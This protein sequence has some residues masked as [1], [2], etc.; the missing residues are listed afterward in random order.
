MLPIKAS[1]VTPT[2]PKVGIKSLIYTPKQILIDSVGQICYK[3]F[4]EIRRKAMQTPEIQ[5][6]FPAWVRSL[7]LAILLVVVVLPMYDIAPASGED[8]S[9]YFDASHP[10]LL[11]LGN[12][13]YELG[14]NKSNGGIAYITD[15]TSLGQTTLGS[16]NG[17][18]WG[19]V[20][21]TETFW[22][23]GCSY[24]KDDPG[25]HF[26]YLWSAISQ[27]LSLSYTTDPGYVQRLNATVS[28][29]P[30]EE[31]WLDLRL[32]LDNQY[33]KTFIYLQMPCE[34]VFKETDI[35]Q[36]LLPMLPGVIL[37][38]SFFTD[39]RSFTSNYPG[40]PGTFADLLHITTTGGKL[41]LYSLF[42]GGDFRQA[43]LGFVHSWDDPANL[44]TLMIH[45]YA[46]WLK[47]GQSITL[48][49]VRL[50]IGE[51]VS[52][53]IL[54]YRDENGLDEFSTPAQKLG[55]LYTQTINGPLYK[56]DAVQLGIPF[57]EY[58]SKIFAKIPYPGIIHPVEFQ[59]GGH[60]HNY[61]DFLPPDDQWGTTEDM[62]AMFRQAQAR[63][64]LVMPYTN[65]T[66]WNDSSPTLLNLPEGI[67]IDDIAVI[68][69]LGNPMYEYYGPN[70]G[71]VMSPYP[72][73]VQQRIDRMHT[74]M[75]QDIPSDMIFEDQIGARAW[76]FDLNASSPSPVNYIQGWIDQTRSHVVHPLHTEQ[77]FDRLA[78]TESAFH[79]S[80]ML[81]KRMG[82]TDAMWGD[83]NWEYYPLATLLV[84]D[85]VLF[86]QHDL[87]PETFV[88]SK[89]VLIWD[90]AMGFQLSYDLV[91]T[92]YGGGLSSPW[93]EISG[94]FQKYLLSH[95]ADERL[96]SFSGS[97]TSHSLTTFK[98]F[99]AVANWRTDQAYTYLGY[100]LPPQGV[101]A[102]HLTGE[103]VGG[104]F[105]GYNGHALS[106]GD[107]FLIEQRSF[108]QIILRQ[109]MG[110]DTPIT[111][112]AP[113]NWSPD[114]PLLVTAYAKDGSVLANL[115][116]SYVDQAINFTY[117]GSAADQKVDFVVVS[118]PAV[119]VWE[120]Y[121]PWV[122]RNSP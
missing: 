89:E 101:V 94:A 78:G 19:A 66:W 70:G 117:V 23:G 15:K 26:S 75:T 25:R 57:N 3:S 6:T 32:Q 72:D 31:R 52:Q 82:F 53:A 74:E 91:T 105:T 112:F 43:T 9:I 116:Y 120:Q 86:F 92:T 121:L 119:K 109:I 50:R 20:D 14:L 51:E 98:T 73:F 63:G 108:H 28:I 106:S 80:V 40:Y 47:D 110:A 83:A 93:M 58:D 76:M 44:T 68:D 64:F 17:C 97:T 114:D 81:H 59:P 107:H 39:Q 95:Y 5:L 67:T 84:R 49:I 65:P 79:G 45:Q 41:S 33:E 71:Y 62:A 77:G 48:P 60:D 100:T 56:T 96:M 99:E 87:A 113:S 13:Y 102:R 55:S 61:P 22:I 18:L 111:L 16:H 27:T 7:V 37:K 69:R 4:N 122:S 30:S 10:D 42:P 11:K 24:H 21:S 1:R 35:E 8:S 29:Q 88:A 103:L 46:A 54:A 104:I 115:S 90:L 36:A 34:L 12:A 38:S 2:H 118:N 85:R